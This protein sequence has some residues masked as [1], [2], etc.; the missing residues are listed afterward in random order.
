MPTKGA[1]IERQPDSPSDGLGQLTRHPPVRA[2]AVYGSGEGRI[3][4]WHQVGDK[5][6]IVGI[7]SAD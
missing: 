7:V 5:V 6:L 1:S 4:L 2:S 3:L